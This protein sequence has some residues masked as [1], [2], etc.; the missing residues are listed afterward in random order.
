MVKKSIYGVAGAAALGLFLFGTSLFSFMHTAVKDARQAARDNVPLEYRLKEAR[1]AVE[2][3]VPDIRQSM[4]VIA[5]QQVELEHL[6]NEIARKETDVQDRRNELYALN[7]EF[8]K[9][10]REYVFAGQSYTADEVKRDLHNR[11]GRL[12]VAEDS[13]KRDQDI[14]TAREESLRKNE[15]LLEEMLARKQDLEIQL[16]QLAERVKTEKA[17]EAASVLDIDDSQLAHAKKLI[18]ELNMQLD[19]KSKLRAAE[20][21]LADGIPVDATSVVPE[22]ISSEVDSY[23]GNDPQL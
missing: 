15:A 20:G 16:A 23:L 9:G 19:V 2:Q 3:I 17:Q 22:D 1:G 12:R 11:L 8:K 10:E 6:K 14:L 5:E 7:E 18:D 4:H 21:K 13:L